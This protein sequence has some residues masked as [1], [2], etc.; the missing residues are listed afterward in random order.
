MITPHWLGGFSKDLDDNDEE[1]Y[2]TGHRLLAILGTDKNA[3]IMVGD[4]GY[5]S[6]Y[7]DQDTPRNH[8]F[9]NVVRDFSSA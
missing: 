7:L 8:D 1:F 2:K 6:Y 5:L 9:S 4:C 3:E